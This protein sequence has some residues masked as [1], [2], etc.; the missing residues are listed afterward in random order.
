MVFYGSGEGWPGIGEAC[1]S[2]VV[3][4]EDL[5]DWWLTEDSWGG[6]M[7]ELFNGGGKG[8]TGDENWLFFE[9]LS[10]LLK[11]RLSRGVLCEDLDDCWQTENILGG[12]MN[13]LFNRSGKGI[14]GD[15][16]LLLFEWQSLRIKHRLSLKIVRCLP[17]FLPVILLWRLRTPFGCGMM[18]TIWV[19]GGIVWLLFCLLMA[20]RRWQPTFWRDNCSHVWISVSGIKLITSFLS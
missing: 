12:L 1:N 6:L 15:E 16:N 7:T 19:C 2:G 10:L 17:W 9:L 20:I 4:C 11:H 14:T 3:F 13:E 5:D 8:I 18:N